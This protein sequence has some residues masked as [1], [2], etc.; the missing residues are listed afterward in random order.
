MLGSKKSLSDLW[1]NKFSTLIHERRGYAIVDLRGDG[2]CAWL[3]H[4]LCGGETR[5]IVYGPHQNEVTKT[6]RGDSGVSNLLGLRGT[7]SF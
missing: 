2:R 6:F 4:C 1:C 5:P 7:A 3:L